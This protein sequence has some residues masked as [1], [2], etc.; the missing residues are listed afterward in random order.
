MKRLLVAGLALGLGAAALTNSP[1]N[2]ADDLAPVR[3]DV[4]ALDDEDDDKDGPCETEARWIKGLKGACDEGGTKAAK[5]LMKALVK[6]CKKAV[7]EADGAKAAAKMNCNS[8]HPKGDNTKLKDG[9]DGV[10]AVK[11]K[12]KDVDW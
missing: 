5:K 4:V 12:C 10:K 7:K 3:D 1:A 8:C 2:A 6:K 11:A 9:E